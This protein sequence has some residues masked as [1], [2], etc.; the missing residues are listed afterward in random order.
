MDGFPRC[1]PRWTHRLL[2]ESLKARRETAGSFFWAFIHQVPWRRYRKD[3]VAAPAPAGLQKACKTA[4]HKRGIAPLTLYAGASAPETLIPQH[5]S[6]GYSPRPLSFL[7]AHSRN[8]G[9]LPN[10]QGRPEQR[11]T[12]TASTPFLK[13]FWGDQHATQ[14]SALSARGRR[15]V[16]V[17]HLLLW[18]GVEKGPR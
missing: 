10:G 8:P 12:H 3:A 18:I 7:R 13:L 11:L 17:R 14:T 4:A 16:E 9:P 5:I 6:S 1:R 15:G 2:T